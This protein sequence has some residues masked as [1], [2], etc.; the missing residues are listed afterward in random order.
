MINDKHLQISVG[1]VDYSEHLAFP[2]VIQDTGTEQL[3]TAIV[4]LSN[5]ST[6]EKFAPFTPVSLCGGKYSYVV[7]ND[8]V[9]EVF[10]RR[11]WHHEL[12][13]IDC[14]KSAERLLMEAKS[15]TQPL[16]VDHF[17]NQGIAKGV[18]YVQNN[19]DGSLAIYPKDLEEFNVRENTYVSPIEPPSDGFK[20]YS[21]NSVSG[22]VSTADGYRIT[23]SVYK[24]LHQAVT[25]DIA[26]NYEPIATVTLTNPT[27]SATISADLVSGSGMYSIIYDAVFSYSGHSPIR[28][29]YAVFVSIINKAETKQ[30]YS[31][32]DLLNILLDTAEPLRRGLDTRR[33]NL[34]LTSKQAE[35]LASMTAPEM[36][37]ENGRSL[38]ENLAQVGKV[39]HAI[40]RID[41]N[42]N[43]YFKELGSAEFADMRK[44]ALFGASA[45][46][47]A[48]DFA[49][50]IEANFAN[51]INTDDESE[52]S[53]TEPYA[54]GYITLRS[55][56]ARIKE[57]TGII[58]TQFPI[59]KVKT[60]KVQ[61]HNEDGTVKTFFNGK[62]YIDITKYLFEKN[63]YDLLSSYSGIYPFTKTYAMYYTTNGQSIDGLWYRAE[64]S[65]FPILNSF[66]R[67]AISNIID[68]AG[69]GTIENSDI[70]AFL[71]L[72][73]QVTYIPII[74]GRVRQER[75]E[76]VGDGKFVLAHN[77]S[78]NKMSAKAF[79]ENMR[80]QIAMMGNPSNSKMYLF[81]SLDDVPKAGTLF[82][83]THYISTITTRVFSGFCVCQ[84]DLSA[85]YNDFGAYAD[86]KTDIRQYEIPEGQ[87]R[88]TLLEE[89]CVI[90]K[91]ESGE[92]DDISR[93]AQ[94]PLMQ[95]VID[96]FGNTEGKTEDITAARVQTYE[97]AASGGLK[98]L[99][100]PITLPVYSTS[101]GNSVY[102]GFAF[103]DNF[104]AG[105]RSVSV[106]ADAY[107]GTE[108]VPY[109]DNF[110]A[111]AKYINF[112]LTT[113]LK[114]NTN[115]SPKSIANDLPR[116][117]VL[118]DKETYVS[119]NMGA[120][121]WNKDS[122]DVGNVAYQLHFV[123]ND[124][125]II[126][127]ELASMM[128][129]V[130]TSTGKDKAAKIYFY[131]KRVN[132]LTGD[133]PLG[134]TK[135]AEST[136]KLPE[137]GSYKITID[138]IPSEAFESWVIKREDGSCIIGKNARTVD[139]EIYFTFKRKR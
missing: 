115:Y 88:C 86:I 30:P 73:F 109:G 28:K 137:D 91:D 14:T 32:F 22:Q 123:S 46:Y 65:A 19:D 99:S 122:A 92:A 53:V 62:D 29:V 104:S 120:L 113:S 125:Y 138:A 134:A 97:D 98:A 126:G 72:A 34:A 121:I 56:D 27:V 54:D 133:V 7:A 102:F 107:R 3:A 116:A 55:N 43:V 74:N 117:S 58:Q 48:S 136:L 111:S 106:N 70:D 17:A 85:N 37:F 38:Y 66:K 81:K 26:K 87:T 60:L 15:F 50:A 78:A 71:R 131:D 52:G 44:G 6:D 95:G 94:A 83:D 130:R 42:N 21:L 9:R 90:G 41:A 18:S 59:A 77:Q 114:T 124:G 25:P 39:I 51:L 139:N 103:K 132:Q 68:D 61:I 24:D 101:V 35:E 63:E 89:Y 2:F 47:N 96:A 33:F 4:T 10:G 1:G 20:I 118:S 82:D 135:V 23:A 80:G 105:S 79:G 127:S 100:D 69:G 57:G 13:L 16:V 11:R 119:T 36:H 129:F 75:T 110:Y 93:M 112:S 67:Y 40:P 31:M 128:P 45:Q 8:A 108:Y 84:F 12:T 5:L 64:D 76:S 49:T